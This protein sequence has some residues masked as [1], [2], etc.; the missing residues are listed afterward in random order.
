MSKKEKASSTRKIVI[1]KH[2]PPHK[3][4]ERRGQVSSRVENSFLWK[5]KVANNYIIWE[6]MKL[7]WIRMI[8]SIR[9]EAIRT[10]VLC[11][12]TL[13]RF[14]FAMIV[15][16]IRV[17]IDLVLAET[18]EQERAGRTQLT[19]QSLVWLKVCALNGLECAPFI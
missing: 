12:N 16:R 6:K 1:S 7:E 4:K 5:K 19:I 9:I 18:V 3:E 14:H 15:K 10:W 11:R 2:K 13:G 17:G 8:L